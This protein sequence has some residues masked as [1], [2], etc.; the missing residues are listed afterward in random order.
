[1]HLSDDELTRREFVG[2]TLATGIAAAV[3]DAAPAGPTGV[4]CALTINGQLHELDLEPRI[5]L[6]DLLRERLQFTGSKKGC[7]H[8]QCGA[9]TVLV[10]G[11]RIVSCLSLAVSLDGSKI[12]TIEG[13]SDGE[14]LHPMQSAFIEHDA[15]QC[16][17]CTS[18]QICSAVAMLEEARTGQPSAV[19][20]A[21]LPQTGVANAAP[22]NAQALLDAEEIRERMS[23]NICRCGAYPNI[24]AAIQDA[25]RRRTGK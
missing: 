7:D 8:G 20:I 12:T 11:S 13:L 18:G 4:A 16:G 1:M 6:L 10:N 22:D 9:C 21:R 17:F 25:S 14:N 19:T 5:T 24:V 3:A 15:F 23:G 2:V